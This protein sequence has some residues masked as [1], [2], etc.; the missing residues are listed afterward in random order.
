MEKVDAAKARNDGPAI[1]VVRDDDSTLYLYGT[2]HLLPSD[3]DWQRDDLNAAFDQA[4]TVFFEVPSNE[5]ARI[6]SERLTRTQGFQPAGERLSE[7]WDQYAV[8]TLEIASVSGDIPLEV[9]DTL[10]PWLAAELITIAAA[11]KAGLSSALSPDEA[12]KSRA[13]RQGKFIRYLDT[14]EDQMALSTNVPPDVQENNLLALLE[15]YNAIGPELQAIAA[16]WVEGDVEALERRLAR[17]ITGASRERMLD[18]R[19]AEWADEL[20]DWMDGSG[21]GLAAVGVAHLVGEGSLVE[22]L[23]ARDLDVRR[24]YAFQ[25]ENV[26]RTIDLDN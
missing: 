24:H 12:L 11:E 17:S 4:G 16:E 1:W 5:S 10:E 18:A 14:V 9:L 8:K 22:L 20:E 23:Q 15:R 6:K 25:G 13:E 7:G 2:M 21:T 3:L 19:N 26:I